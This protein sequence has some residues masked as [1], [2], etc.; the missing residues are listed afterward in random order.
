MSTVAAERPNIQKL[1]DRVG[2]TVLVALGGLL[3]KCIVLDVKVGYGTEYYQLQPVE[4]SGQKWTEARLCT[5][6]E[7]AG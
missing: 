3:V 6:W 7:K 2:D 5:P 4:G 1:A